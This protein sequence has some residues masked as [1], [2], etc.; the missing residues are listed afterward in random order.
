MFG[1][2]IGTYG[3]STITIDIQTNVTTYVYSG[4]SIANSQAG[5]LQFLGY[6]TS[7]SEYFTG[8]N[9]IADNGSGNLPGITDVSLGHSGTSSVP[10][11][12]TILLFGV[13]LA[14][15]G[16]FVCRKKS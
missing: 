2:N 9:I 4:L 6:Q 12:T 14:G 1:F 16:G 13:G 8:F 5:M 10:E 3:S 15:L 7:P 11:P